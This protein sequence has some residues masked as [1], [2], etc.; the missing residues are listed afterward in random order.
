MFDLVFPVQGEALPADHA[1]PLFAVLSHLVP[2]FHDPA[3][4]TRF[5][6]IAGPRFD[7]GLL[8][9]TPRATLRV[10]LP[11]ERIGE[12]I[13]LAGKKLD[14]A[15]HAVRLG[16]P[17]VTVLEPAATLFARVVSIKVSVGPRGG[18]KVKGRPPELEAFV[19]SARRML[20]ERGIG[21]ELGVPVKADGPRAGEAVRRVVRIHGRA[22]VGYGVTVTGLTAADSVRLQEEGL[23]G[24]L[25][26]G[27]GFFL[28]VRGV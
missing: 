13:G 28:P 4:N 23:G 2:A 21:G 25:R 24:R 18:R 8:R 11:Q 7:R 27:C 6:P 22:I 1:Y 26:I 15:G 3:A 20:S 14:V 16:V 19:A 10:R 17:F 9:V 5:A 12:V